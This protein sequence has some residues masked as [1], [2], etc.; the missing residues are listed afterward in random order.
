MDVEHI[1]D[2]VALCTSAWI[3][4]SYGD[5]DIVTVCVALCTSAWIEI[6][7]RWRSSS[8]PRRCRTLYECVD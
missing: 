6:G 8:A 3:E 2:C 5:C 4:I 1:F 7:Q